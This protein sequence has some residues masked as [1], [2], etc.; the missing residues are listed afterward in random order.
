MF[1]TY[2]IKKTNLYLLLSVAFLIIFY[3]T[4]YIHN[5]QHSSET[6]TSNISYNVDHQSFRLIS[7]LGIISQIIEKKPNN[8]WVSLDSVLL[9]TQIICLVTN[10]DSISYWNKSRIDPGVLP[11]LIS[12]NKIHCTKLTSGWYLYTSNKSN[13]YTAYVFDLIRSD[14]QMNNGL[15]VPSFSGNYSNNNNIKLTLDE[16]ESINNIYNS[17]GQFLFGIIINPNIGELYHTNVL[18]LFF[19][20]LCYLTLILG[21]FYLIKNSVIYSNKPS[22]KFSLFV[23]LSLVIWYL[24]NRFNFP[25]EL[26][27][28][29]FFDPTIFNIPLTHSY[30]DLILNTLHIAIISI[31]A[32]LFF[33][34]TNRLSTPIQIIIRYTILWCFILIISYIL[35]FITIDQ[36]ISFLAEATINF[37]NL[38]TPI[39][40]FVGLNVS[41][42]F[43]LLPFLNQNSNQKIPILIPFILSFFGLLI[44]Y[45]LTNIP[46]LLLFTVLGVVFSIIIIQLFF[47]RHITDMFF[48]HIL[49]LMILSSMSATVINMALKQKAD[50]YQQH[51]A[52]TLAKTS[53]D[54]FETTFT[55]IS[56]QI[57]NDDYLIKLIFSDTNTLDSK[58]EEY[59]H[60]MYFGSFSNKYNIQLTICGSD[61]LIEIQPEGKIYNCSDYFNSIINEITFQTEDSSLFRFN[62]GTESIYYISR[63]TLLDPLNKSLSRNLYIEFVSSHVPE[64]LGYPELLVDSK[65]QTLNLSEFSFAKYSNNILTYK[66]GDFAY[67]TYFQATNNFLFNSFFHYNEYRHFA[68]SISPETYLIVSRT[69][70]SMTMKIVVFALI[71]MI[72][73]LISII[74]YFIIYAK[75]AINLFRLNFKTRLQTFVIATLTITFV[76]MA[77]STLI[78][79]E[80]SSKEDLEKQLLEKTNSVLI[81]L[82]HKL[83]TVSDLENEDSENLHQLLRKFSL[84]FFSDINLY[85]K[86]GL[87]VATSRPEIFEKSLLS[88]YIN[89]EAYKAIFIDNKLNFITEEKIGALSYYS[90]YVPINLNNELPIGI[91]NLPYFARQSEFTKSY[92]IML[93]YLINIYVI[94]GIIGALIAITFSRYLTRPLVLLQDSISNIRIDKHNEKINWNKNDEIGQLIKEYNRMVDKLEQSADLLKHSERE[95]AWREVAKQIAHEIK[96]PLTPM[97]LNVQYLEKSFKNKDPEFASKIDSI[98]KSLIDQIDT[99]DNVAEM[100]SNFAKSKSL[101]FEEVDLKNSLKSSINLFDKKSNISINIYFGENCD[102]LITLGFEKDILRVINNLIK[103]AVQAIE[104]NTSG[105]IDLKVRHDVKYIEVSISDNGKGI[106]DDMKSNIFQPYFTTKTSGTGLGLAI[107]KNIMNEIGGEVY[108]KSKLGSGTTFILRFPNVAAGN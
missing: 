103:N 79:I 4:Q 32:Y 46:I 57:Y 53:D 54:T 45:I 18:V 25:Y 60:D 80:D 34:K 61:E 76:L 36:N 59:L 3:F 52:Q 49:L 75:K 33:G 82:Q 81:E 71:F 97:K 35:Y 89:P 37:N 12:D 38:F 17:S 88:S 56:N 11:S 105:I 55:E 74:A 98:S 83:S 1:G 40:I 41:L 102:T 30:G 78:Y 90:S 72:F 7:G 13:D 101:E 22:L 29:S 19:F 23:I 48:K 95:S 63:I 6:E 84:V 44:V 24:I 91:V 47:W 8:Y 20:I 77:V 39:I 15:L 5:T 9:N 42:Y 93:S 51:I 66:F 106:P 99:L 67:N 70:T 96:N 85:D 27:S 14:Y 107:V 68:I 31:S 108:F 43:A 69:H 16:D 10:K 86:S 104:N 92:Y 73:S 50:N 100:F 65:S 87:L 21:I 58:I 2:I 94:I 64:G 26:K 28:S 62:S